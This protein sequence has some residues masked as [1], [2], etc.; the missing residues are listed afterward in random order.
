ME[1]KQ[2]EVES[3]EQCN[4]SMEILHGTGLSMLNLEKNLGMNHWCPE[5]AV[6]QDRPWGQK[7]LAGS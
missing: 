6:G 5:T 7:G 4:G 3:A 1:V 2:Q